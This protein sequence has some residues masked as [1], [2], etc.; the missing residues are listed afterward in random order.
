MFFAAPLYLIFV[1]ILFLVIPIM[2]GIYVYKDAGSRGMNASLWTLIAVLSPAVIGLIIYL[3]VRSDYRSYECPN[4]SAPVRSEYSACPA[5]GTQLKSSCAACG[6]ALEPTWANCPNCGEA[7]PA[8][9]R[10]PVIP[11]KRDKGL[12][13]LLAA[14]I[15]IP[16]MIISTLAIGLIYFR[17]SSSSSIG[18][19]DGMR[20]EDY[21]RD[22]TVSDW[23]KYC[24]ASGN[25][26]YVLEYQYPNNTKS[27]W[28]RSDYIVYRNGLTKDVNVSAMGGPKGLFSGDSLKI[29]YTDLDTKGGMNYHIYQVDYSTTHSTEL[30][31]YVN[32]IKTDYQLTRSNEPLM[33]VDPVF[34][35]NDAANLY[36]LRLA[37]LGDNSGVGRLLEAT[38]LAHLGEYQMELETA[39]RP[40]GL[41]INYSSFI[42]KF[43]A[44][45]FS[46]NATEFLGLIQNLDYITI[47][48]GTTTYKLTAD[49]ASA[50]L[51][52]DVKELGKT[53]EKLVEYLKTVY[54]EGYMD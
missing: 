37:H 1:V 46:T 50:A 6:R 16:I 3:L 31:I 19:G 14:V 11:P 13:K 8:D 54:D 26:I 53:P 40:Y 23:L 2:I 42:D 20:I 38:G 44:Y 52:Y 30:E 7:V 51:G 15:L 47:T 9:G 4:C 21:A 32:G 17:T 48:G 24:D 41:H 27:G 18:S 5:C 22:K 25:G 10:L 45:D 39:Q 12:G 29:E 43:E 35:R 49:E 34:W 36:R 28:S 33:F